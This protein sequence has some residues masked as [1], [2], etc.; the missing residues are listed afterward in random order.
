MVV[1]VLKVHKSASIH[2]KSES[3]HHKS[4]S[5]HKKIYTYKIFKISYLSWVRF[6]SNPYVP[7]AGCYFTLCGVMRKG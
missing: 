1:S 3:I 7:L 2:D 5:I 6:K 4:A